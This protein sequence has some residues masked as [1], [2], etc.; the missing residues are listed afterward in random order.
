MTVLL[1]DGLSL[2]RT[3]HVLVDRCDLMCADERVTTERSAVDATNRNRRCVGFLDRQL[4]IE[5]LQH[6]G[7][8]W[9]LL[10][11]LNDARAE[12]ISGALDVYPGLVDAHEVNS[13]QIP[14]SP[15]QHFDPKSSQMRSNVARNG[16]NYRQ[17]SVICKRDENK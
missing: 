8:V 2:C 14:K 4:Q 15:E 9:I 13:F 12:N 11:V 17:L 6:A 3:M 1:A 10:R 16:E 5:E 7:E